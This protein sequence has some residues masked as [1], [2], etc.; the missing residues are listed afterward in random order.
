MDTFF[1]RSFM[2][3]RSEHWLKL[4]LSNNLFWLSYATTTHSLS[5]S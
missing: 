5:F 1:I 4:N 2:M 3:T